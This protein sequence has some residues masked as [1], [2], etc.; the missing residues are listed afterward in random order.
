M[1]RWFLFDSSNNLSALAD[2]DDIKNNILGFELTWTATQASEQ[3]YTDVVKE[4]KIVSYDGITVSLGNTIVENVADYNS[5]VF[6]TWK[7]NKLEIIKN[8]L[9]HHT[10]STW[11]SIFTQLQSFSI[12][13]DDYVNDEL[14][15][16]SWWST[17]LQ[18]NNISLKN[19][20]QL[21]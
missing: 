13:E 7:N 9:R 4:T 16:G 20:L 11:S 6:E 17:F 10:D 18:A 3:D 14:P 12:T 15:N 8:Y 21:Y 2:N 1:A 5:D 19:T